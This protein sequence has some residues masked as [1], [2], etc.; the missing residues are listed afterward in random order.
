MGETYVRPNALFEA[1]LAS[2]AMRLPPARDMKLDATTNLKRLRHRGGG[3]AR[4]F[5][6]GDNNSEMRQSGKLD[7]SAFVEKA[8]NPPARSQHF[9][10]LHR[11]ATWCHV[12]TRSKIKITRPV[13][14]CTI[15]SVL[16]H[17]WWRAT[18][19]WRG[20]ILHPAPSP[21]HTVGQT[22]VYCP[23]GNP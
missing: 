21:H 14:A 17:G 15:T 13:F 16:T 3:S 23:M 19:D 18:I 7:M 6:L 5:A 1:T 22:K 8:R 11:N 2:P 4:G 10:F 20:L 12:G 9:L